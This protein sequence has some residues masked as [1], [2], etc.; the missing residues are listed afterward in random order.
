MDKLGIA[1]PN[2]QN[3]LDRTTWG[4]TPL[5]LAVDSRNQRKYHDLVRTYN[6]LTT[7]NSAT[8]LWYGGVP[9]DQWRNRPRPKEDDRTKDWRYIANKTTRH[10]HDERK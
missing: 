1:G 5:D 2:L 10:F 7:D 8:N 9:Y 4:R 3:T 6:M